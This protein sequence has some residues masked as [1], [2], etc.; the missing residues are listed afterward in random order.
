MAIG[1]C[2]VF[3]EIVSGYDFI[4]EIFRIIFPGGDTCAWGVLGVYLGCGLRCIEY[5][6]GFGC[7][8]YFEGFG[9]SYRCSFGCSSGNPYYH[10]LR[11]IALGTVGLGVPGAVGKPA[12]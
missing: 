9:C 11:A 6:E 1:L 5:F 4:N 3:R 7:I 12:L 2:Y 8:E 10:C